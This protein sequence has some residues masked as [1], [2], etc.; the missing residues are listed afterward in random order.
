MNDFS[1]YLSERL[2]GFS[3]LAVLGVGSVLRADD[4]AGMQIVQALS[5]IIPP[6]SNPD[7]RFFAGE[8]APENF[9][10]KIKQFMPS[11]LLIV[12]AA[13]V[14]LTPGSVAEISPDDVGGPSF[15]SHMLPLKIMIDYLI[16]ETGADVIL[17]GL[18]YKSLAFDGPMTPEMNQAVDDV[19]HTLVQIILTRDEPHTAR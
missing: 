9:S 6:A 18:Q 11:H 7:V 1:L 2:R 14:G 10:G 12:D 4:A 8:T 15:C 5:E 13:D 17:L 16:A 3:R 19:C